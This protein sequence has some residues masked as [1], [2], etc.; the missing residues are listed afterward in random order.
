MSL[1]TRTRLREAP[2]WWTALAVVVALLALATKATA[3]LVVALV[4]LIERLAV[5]LMAA[6]TWC[7]VWA[8]GRA[9]LPPLA[10]DGGRR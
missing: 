8:S 9:G 3:L 5:L 2:G 10:S 4:V 7:D 1:E 6:V